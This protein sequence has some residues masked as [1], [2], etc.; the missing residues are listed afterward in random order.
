M[1]FKKTLGSI[2][3]AGAIA[4]RG[5]SED[6]PKPEYGNVAGQVYQLYQQELVYGD[7]QGYGS[8]KNIPIPV[9]FLGVEAEGKKY[10]IILAG[11]HNL[12]QGDSIDLDYLVDNEVTGKEIWSRFYPSR[13]NGRLM[14]I[15]DVRFK[16]NGYAT[17]WKKE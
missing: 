3:L 15:P 7:N 13:A 8:G 1:I 10:Q 14:T 6:K 9:T 4:L 12:R 16:A 5:C 17:A 11:P 2:I